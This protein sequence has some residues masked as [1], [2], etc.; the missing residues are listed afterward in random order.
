MSAKSDGDRIAI[1]GNW[2][3]K[4]F[5]CKRLEVPPELA[6]DFGELL[7]GLTRAQIVQKRNTEAACKGC[8]ASIDPIGI[9]FERFDEAG[10][11]DPS[12]DLAP[13]GLDPS[14][15]DADADFESVAEL[16][17]LL[18]DDPE[19]SAC[20]TARVF[21][22][23]NGREPARADSCAVESAAQTF[24]GSSHDFP[25]LLRGLVEAPGFRLRRAP[26][27]TP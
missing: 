1:R 18:R 15:P 4:T 20:L 5:L 23:A 22:Y 16:A 14:F 3:R 21:L 12:V 25:T 27:G 17:S 8:H 2:L 24:A 6:E 13:F 19:V 9:G 26:P 7:V 10:R 11:Y